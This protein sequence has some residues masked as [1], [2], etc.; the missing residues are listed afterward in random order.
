MKLER[1]I[2]IFDSLGVIDVKYRKHAVWIDDIHKED[3]TANVMDLE[4]HENM[5]V[6][7]EQLVEE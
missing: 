4:T 7:V 2:E 1:A 6:P 5:L 3:K